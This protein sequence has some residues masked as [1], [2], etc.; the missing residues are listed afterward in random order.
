MARRST[1]FDA[2]MSL[3]QRAPWYVG[4]IVILALFGLW[5]VGP[6][7]LQ[8]YTP[9]LALI[10]GMVW[11]VAEGQKLVDRRRLDDTKGIEDIRAMTWR[12]FERL[13][14]EAFR[15]QGYQ[16]DHSGRD[17]PDGGVDIWLR[18]PGEVTLVQCKH[19]KKWQVPVTTVRELAGLVLVK[20]GQ[21]G[22]VVTSGNFSWAAKQFAQ[23]SGIRLIGG[24]EL[25]R[26]V[27]D[28]RVDDA[29][30]GRPTGRTG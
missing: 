3:F 18:R 21:R 16:V 4:L 7:W 27:A 14:C 22:I 9:F 28:V 12:E 8:P 15:R 2:L 5:W 25:V 26:I 6:G 17:G 29:K 11:L 13:L 23:E 30:N 19:W 20:P 24:D 10:F 1:L